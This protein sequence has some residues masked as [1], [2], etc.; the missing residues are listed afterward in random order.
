MAE[1][2]KNQMGQ[3]EMQT[4][5][6]EFILMHMQNVFFLLGRIPTPDGKPGQVNL[7]LAKVLIDQLEM[8]EAKTQNNLSPDESKVLNNALANAR[9]AFVETAQ[10]I[11]TASPPETASSAGAEPKISSPPKD[12]SNEDN[13]EDDNKKRFTKKYG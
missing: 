7:D 5:F 1:V 3:S 12:E 6:V 2:Q 4:R 13:S 11:P 10:G 8:I 9:L